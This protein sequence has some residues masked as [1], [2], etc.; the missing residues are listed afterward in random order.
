MGSAGTEEKRT[1]GLDERRVG[2]LASCG[3]GSLLESPEVGR[4]VKGVRKERVGESAKAR[5]G[6]KIERL[7]E[8]K[9]I[10][11]CCY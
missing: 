4:G 11:F 10:R 7:G 1:R 5:K 6:L 9:N 3:S 2:A 8:M